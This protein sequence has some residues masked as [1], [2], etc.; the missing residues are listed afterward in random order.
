MAAADVANPIGPLLSEKIEPFKDQQKHKHNVR[1]TLN[2]YLD[3]GQPP[4][5][6]YVE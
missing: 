2:Y 6:T 1:A 3:E 5:P 4:A